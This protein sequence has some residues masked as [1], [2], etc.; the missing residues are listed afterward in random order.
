MVWLW[1]CVVKAVGGEGVLCCQGTGYERVMLVECVSL[2]L[3]VGKVCC[4]V[5]SCS[6]VVMLLCQG[7]AS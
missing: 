3:L 1:V 7:L 5:F 6:M 2:G 4:V